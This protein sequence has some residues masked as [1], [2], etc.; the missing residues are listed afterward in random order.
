MR[1]A[2]PR[3]SPEGYVCIK[4]C[5]GIWVKFRKQALQKESKVEEGRLMPDHVHMLLSIRPKY[6]V[7][8]ARGFIKGES[9]FHLAR[10]YET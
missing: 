8:H 9:A 5:S 4:G 6:P 1:S 2:Q 10:L 7:S 3:P